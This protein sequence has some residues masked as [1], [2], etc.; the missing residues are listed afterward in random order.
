[1]ITL[2]PSQAIAAE[3]TGTAREIEQQFHRGEHALAQQRLDQALSQRPADVSLRFL[4]GVFLTETDRA[5]EAVSLF[6]LLTQEFPELPEPYNN[7]AVLQASAGRFG[8]A[9]ELLETA[10]RLDPSYLT[11]HENL[12]DVFVRLALASYEAAAAGTRN[13]PRLMN[14]LRLA[15]DLAVAR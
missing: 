12:G 15:R 5:A 6:E 4:K 11:A 8:A 1:M 3:P 2:L 7:L 10:L 9:R 14:K 13:E